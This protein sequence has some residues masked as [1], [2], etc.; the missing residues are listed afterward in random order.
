M[1]K[2]HFKRTVVRTVEPLLAPFG[3]KFNNA[4]QKYGDYLFFEK[5][6]PDEVGVGFYI[7]FQLGHHYIPPRRKFTV[8]LQRNKGDFYK[9]EHGY[10]KTVRWRLGSLIFA[11]YKLNLYPFSDHWWEFENDVELKTQLEDAIEKL[12][13]Y[14]LP[15]LEDP[16]IVL[17]WE[18]I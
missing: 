13:E 18:F 14:G 10:E 3:Y 7:V 15:W 9:P 12:I 11:Y 17:P 5:S 8:E 16:N 4:A 6:S 1:T 2:I